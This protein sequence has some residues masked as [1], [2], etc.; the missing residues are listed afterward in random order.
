MY[1]KEI[2]IFENALITDIDVAETLNFFFSDA[3]KSLSINE[4]SYIINGTLGITDPIDIAFKKF[5]SHPSILKIKENVSGTRFS[6]HTITLEEVELE[7]SMCHIV[8]DE[9]GNTLVMYFF[10]FYLSVLVWEQL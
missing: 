9:Y 7:I 8:W 5:E 3:P 10:K 6:F 1:N 4:N 2:I